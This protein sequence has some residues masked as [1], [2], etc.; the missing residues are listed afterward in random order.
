[1]LTGI[2]SVAVLVRDARK[3]AEWY[4]DKLGFDVSVQG[5]WVEAKPKGSRVV[6]HLCEKNSDWED[7]KPGGQTGI[8][9]A[10]DDKERTYHELKIRGVVFDVDLRDAPW[11]ASE[12]PSN[13]Y[14]IFKDPDGN[15]F[16][17]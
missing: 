13:K 14:A 5:H 17:M 7:D 16:W 4:R 12:E 11:G 2:G 9:I 8:F 1:M 6:L 10:C 3:S 15:K